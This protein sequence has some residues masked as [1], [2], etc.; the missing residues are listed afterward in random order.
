MIEEA[1][2]TS[3]EHNAI[4]VSSKVLSPAEK[5]LLKKGPSF[6][7]TPTDINWCNLRQD[8]DSFVN[9]LRF[10][11]LKTAKD[12]AEDNPTSAALSV[13]PFQLGNP[14]VK[15]KSPNINYR[16][17]KANVNSLETFIELVDLFQ[18]C[19]YNKVKSNITKEERNALKDIQHDEMTSCRL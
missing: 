7:P 15:A 19:N 4:N 2:T 12:H 18:P 13:E 5:S 9:K 6:V 8:F 1:K 10:Q 11:A 17:E 3:P 14:P 16:R